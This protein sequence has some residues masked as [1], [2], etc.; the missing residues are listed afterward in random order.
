M[1]QQKQGRVKSSN[2]QYKNTEINDDLKLEREADLMGS[3]LNSDNVIPDS[4]N[5]PTLGIESKQN[6]IQRKKVSTNFGEFETTKFDEA[7]GRGVEIILKFHPDDSKVDAKKIALSQSV[8]HTTKTGIPYGIDPN[9]SA[10]MVGAGESGA[11][12]SIDRI[13]DKN[14]PIYGS[15]NLGTTHSLKDTPK[16]NNSTADSIDLGV[17]ATYE[18]GHC[19][20]KKET[21]TKKEKHSAALWDKPRGGKNKGES[22]VFETAALAIEGA[23]KDKYYGSVKWGYKM[24]G[25]DTTPTVTKIDITETSKGDP[26]PNFIEAAKLW[27]EGKT[28]GTLK[29]TAYPEATVLKGDSSG[30]EKLAK[31]RKLKQLST[32]MWGRSPA[33]KAEILKTDGTGS[34]KIVY[35][36]N[37]DV[38]DIGDGTAN[39]ALPIP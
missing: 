32:V 15:K 14:T 18:L 12:Y 22:R 24:E 21:D 37:N 10:R 23:D 20:K 6:V 29:V 13:S 38:Q 34:G 7:D 25:T 39:K 30:T 28:R 35:V 19:Y 26:T 2:V 27:N 3:K 16:N 8:K 1:V 31:G 33:V 9:T 17:N 5:L 36:K 11:G 4:S